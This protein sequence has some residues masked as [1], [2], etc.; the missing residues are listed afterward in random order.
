MSCR[1][2]LIVLL[3]CGLNSLRWISSVMCCFR[4]MFL[5]LNWRRGIVVKW[6]MK[7]MLCYWKWLIC[8]VNCLISLINSWVISWWWLLICR[9]ISSSWWVFW[10]VWRKFWFSKFFGWIVINWWIGSGLRFFWRC[11]KVSL[12]WWK[13]LWIGKKCGLWCLLF[14]WLVYCCCWLLVLFVGVCSGLRIIR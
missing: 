2:W 4:V 1:I 7:F 14:F 6:M 9:L 5:L 10:V 13:L 8:V 11:W 12:R 3:I